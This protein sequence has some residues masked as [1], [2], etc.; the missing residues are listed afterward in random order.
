MP[1]TLLLDIN[2]DDAVKTISEA[3]GAHGFYILRS[4]DLRSAL[5]AVTVGCECPHH[6]TEKCDCQF[7]VLLIYGE[8]AEPITLTTHSHNHQTRIQIVRDATMNPDPCFVEK[9]MAVLL[10][11]S[12]SLSLSPLINEEATSHA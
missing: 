5:T 7:V 11:A 4:F 2:G 9:V 6:G 1:N 8:A 12:P 10:E 3:L